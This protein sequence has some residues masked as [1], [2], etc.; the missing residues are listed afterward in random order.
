M[1]V[2]VRRESDR[3]RREGI[4]CHVTTAPEPLVRRIDGLQ[5]SAPEQVFLELAANLPLVEL[6]VVGDHMV[7]RRM[8]TLKRLR[9]FCERAT[10]KD[11]AHAR[12][13]VAFVR[14]RVDSPM[15]TRLRML[16]VLAGLPEPEVNLTF[17]DEEGLEFRRYDLSWPG[18]RLIVEYDGRHHIERIEQWESD[19][20]RREKIDDD[21]WRIVVVISKGIYQTPGATV[22][23]IHRL[24]R[25]RGVPGTP[26]RP[27]EEWRKHFSGS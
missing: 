26:V 10:G 17:G 24:L 23:K 21:R 22:A 8:T 5:V 4:R 19:L 13:A 15:E 11:A 20:D 6:V 3:R 7:R 1:H 2:T 9:E 16:I 14:E 18:A 27:S 25:E 12:A